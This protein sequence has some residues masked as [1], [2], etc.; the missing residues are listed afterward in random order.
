M[1]RYLIWLNIPLLIFLSHLSVEVQL[2]NWHF[3]WYFAIVI[4]ALILGV[5]GIIYYFL[6]KII[7]IRQSDQLAIITNMCLILTP[8]LSYLFV[9]TTGVGLFTEAFSVI[10]LVTFCTTQLVALILLILT[11]VKKNAE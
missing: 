11:F 5:I 4:G 8:I 6:E 3:I 9:F 7:A 2:E 1:K 10:F